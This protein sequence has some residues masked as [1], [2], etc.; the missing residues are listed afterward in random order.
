VSRARAQTIGLLTDWITSAY[1]L[2]ILQGAL[3]AARER[4]VNVACFTSGLMPGG[5]G[6]TWAAHAFIGPESLDG[7]VVLAPALAGHSRTERE[8]LLRSLRR[9]PLCSVGIE[10]DGASSVRI[11]NEAGLATAVDHLVQAHGRRRVG[12]VG[13]PEHNV[14]AG[15]RLAG[16]R[17][18]LGRHGLPVDERLVLPGE[19]TVPSGERAV[20]TLFDVRR[21]LLGDVDALV[22][23]N[24]GMAWG[25]LAELASRGIQV[26]D[27]LAITG[28]DDLP[29]ARQAR[30]PLATVRQ[31]VAELGR[32]AV[33]LLLDRIGG[34]RRE[35]LLLPTELVARQSCGCLEGIGRLPLTPADL[36]RRGGRSFDVVLLERQPSLAAE[37]RRAS[38]GQ[39]E[40]LGGG[41]EARLVSA[42]VDELKGRS[43]DSFR[44]ELLAA[45]GRV[46]AARGDLT[47]FQTVVSVLWRHLTPCVLAE[48]A[49]RTTLEGLL[50]GARLH[51]ATAALRVQ[52]AEQHATDALARELTD[53]C[54][55]VMTSSSLRDVAV[56]VEKRFRSLGISRLAVALHPEGQVGGTLLRVLSFDGERAQLERMELGARELPARVLPGTGRS[57]L[58][59]SALHVRGK[60]FGVL[61]LELGS[62]SELVHDAIRDAMSVVLYRM[63]RAGGRLFPSSDKPGS[64]GGLAR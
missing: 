61:G 7:L 5:A 10:L 46:T 26:P 24:D 9:L 49:L 3:E 15:Q 53:V 35:R 29:A 32:R 47:A 37:M 17:A 23:A 60:V 50:D 28:F 20:R 51:I 21:V 40:A 57:E 58:I 2:V 25:C 12:F 64:R 62:P 22:V 8:S 16:Y 4:E 14:E 6:G 18:A 55:A 56:V 34:A 27:Q 52:S 41:W 33:R 43:P 11:D 42:L 54:I 36:R 38:H 45:L 19:F 39:L 48:P 59:I 13:G 63:D 44:K 31:P 30:V 1:H